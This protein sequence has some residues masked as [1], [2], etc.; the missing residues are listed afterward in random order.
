MAIL[1]LAV[2]VLVLCTLVIRLEIKM[3]KLLRN[4]KGKTI[5][6]TIDSID[7]DIK[8]LIAFKADIA[9]Y[10]ASV[11]KRLK[12]SVQGVSTVRF[13]AFNNTNTGGNQSFASALLNE[14]GNGLVVSSLYSRDIVGVYAKPVASGL[15][16]YEL[17]DEEKEAIKQAVECTKNL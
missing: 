2:C 3:R 5:D 11:E 10:L 12:K 8:N 13:N 15:S 9:H 7:K 16:K 6:S 17:S 1:I 14:E 4:G